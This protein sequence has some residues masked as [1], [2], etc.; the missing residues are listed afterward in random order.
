MSQTDLICLKGGLPIAVHRGNM[1]RTVPTGYGCEIDAVTLGQ[2][3][4]INN[5]SLESHPKIS[6][7]QLVPLRV[8]LQKS[9]PHIRMETFLL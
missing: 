7:E 4:A 9:G 1:T 8:V 5:S 2:R 6:S 3:M